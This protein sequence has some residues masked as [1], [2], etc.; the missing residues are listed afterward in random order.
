MRH[1]NGQLSAQNLLAAPFH[2]VDEA[3]AAGGIPSACGLYAWWVRPGAVGD[4]PRV[5]H[6][7]KPFDLLYVGV[8]PSGPASTASLRSRVCNQHIGGNVGSSTFRFGLAALLWKQ[9]GWHPHL[10]SS[11]KVRLTATD[12][13]ALSAWQR[14]HL[15]VSWIV[16]DEPWVPEA[17][18]IAR[19][20]PP[21]NREH[22]QSHP[23]YARIGTARNEFRAAAKPQ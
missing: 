19:L 5:Q 4:V 3:R 12:N 11:G 18:V 9:E 15:R 17:T 7:S 22:N 10:S 14:E 2:T 1:A 16:L 20:K 13:C 8:A 6:P 23:F 21:M